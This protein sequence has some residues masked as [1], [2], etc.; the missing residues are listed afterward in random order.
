MDQKTC[1]NV[2]CNCWR[3]RRLRPR[4]LSAKDEIDLRKLGADEL[5]PLGLDAERVRTAA[6]ALWHVAVPAEERLQRWEA[7]VDSILF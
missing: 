2:F 7:Y 1:R 5:R 4:R 3:R 6:P